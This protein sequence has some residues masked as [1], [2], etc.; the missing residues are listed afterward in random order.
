M[1][2]YVHGSQLLELQNY[3]Q[4]LWLD[5]FLRLKGMNSGVWLGFTDI[6]KKGNWIAL[7]NRKKVTYTNW[8]KGE[9]N[10]ANGKQHCVVYTTDVPGWMD[11]G[12]K[13]KLQ[14]VCKY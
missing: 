6:Q 9:P 5:L 1:Y 10:N 14:F 4:E 2:C 12:C 13:V 7:S 11:H 3:K 8:R